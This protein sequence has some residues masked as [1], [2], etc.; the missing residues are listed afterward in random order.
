MAGGQL[1]ASHVGHRTS[2]AHHRVP[3]D[4]ISTSG[5]VTRRV[6][7]KL[8]HTGI[9]RVHAGTAVLLLIQD[10]H[11]RVLNAATGEQLRELTLDP[12]RNYQP[13]SEPKGPTRNYQ[14]TGEPKGP[15][16][17]RPTAKDPEP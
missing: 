1:R 7:G 9:G 2:D 16:R 3:A 17:P 15:T 8:C 12:T 14:P 13:A 10:L 5:T 4:I 11:I 6:G